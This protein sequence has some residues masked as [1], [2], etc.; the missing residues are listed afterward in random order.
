M[1]L[2]QQKPR[3]VGVLRACDVKVRDCMY[4]PDPSQRKVKASDAQRSVFVLP[5]KGALGK[6]STR[7]FNLPEVGTCFGA[8]AIDD[9]CHVVD[10]M[11]GWP[12]Y[13]SAVDVGNDTII[14]DVIMETKLEEEAKKRKKKKPSKS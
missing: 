5:Q 9:G 1:T 6:P 13:K 2:V 8:P 11:R 14:D 7:H 10:A 4:W 12:N 3:E